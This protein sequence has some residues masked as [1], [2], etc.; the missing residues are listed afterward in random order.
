MKRRGI[1]S[2]LTAESKARGKMWYP[3]GGDLGVATV[4][5]ATT[6]VPARAVASSGPAEPEERASRDGHGAM[7]R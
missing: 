5:A 7:G 2:Q 1:Q 4:T 6:T 3:A